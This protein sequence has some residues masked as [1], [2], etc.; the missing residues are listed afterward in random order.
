MTHE[1]HGWAH[2]TRIDPGP[3]GAHAP[4]VRL[5]LFVMFAEHA[6]DDCRVLVDAYM[7]LPRPE[8]MW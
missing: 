6:D 8:Q 7:P 3:L 2:I 1:R 4:N 5:F